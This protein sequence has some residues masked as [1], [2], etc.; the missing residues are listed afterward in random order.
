MLDIYDHICLEQEIAVKAATLVAVQG[1]I[2]L[3][4]N[5]N[6]FTHCFGA[7]WNYYGNTDTLYKGRGAEVIVS[8]K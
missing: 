2:C 4:L 5:W 8:V 6:G 7:V 3:I 1:H